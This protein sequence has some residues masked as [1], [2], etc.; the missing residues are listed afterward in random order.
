MACNNCKCWQKSAQAA[1][2]D[3]A[4]AY[5]AAGTQ[6]SIMGNL[7]TDT[8]E[9]IT[10]T[11]GGFRINNGGLFRIS[12]DVTSTPTAALYNGSSAMPCAVS[13]VT[14]TAAGIVT[15]HV[16]TVI[17]LATCCA[18]QPT[19]SAHISGVAGTI[20]HVG[21]NAVKLA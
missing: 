2:N 8:G 21:A 9:S 19:I 18:I 14:T 13:T 5:V 17:R 10:T 11:S 6:I 15:Q 4:Q 3:A 1:Y 7:V 16:E 20:N 12:F